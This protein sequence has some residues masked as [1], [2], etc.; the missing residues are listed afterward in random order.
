LSGFSARQRRVDSTWQAEHHELSRSFVRELRRKSLVA[1]RLPQCLQV[2]VLLTFS[3]AESGLE[4]AAPR[5]QKTPP[6]CRAPRLELQDR[7]RTRMALS[8]LPP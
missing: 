7:H 3:L 2:F 8:G 6:A 5:S 4:V 1:F